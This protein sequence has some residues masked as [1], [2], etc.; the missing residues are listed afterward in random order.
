EIAQKLNNPKAARAV[1]TANAR[2]PF[3][4]IIPCHRIITKN[5]KLGGYAGG[6]KLKKYLLEFEREHLNSN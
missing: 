5:G 1:G 4:I 2:N 6:L 3:P